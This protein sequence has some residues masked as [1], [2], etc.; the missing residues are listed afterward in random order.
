MGRSQPSTASPGSTAREPAEGTAE[1]AWWTYGVLSASDAGKL[2]SVVEGIEPGSSV[3]LV[4][5]GELAAMVSAVPADDYDDARLREHLEDLEWVERTARRHEA[6]L[7]AALNHA[8]VVPLRLCTLYRDHA[9]VRLLLREQAGPLEE[10]L[11]KVEGAAEWGVKVFAGNAAVADAEHAG[12]DHKTAAR[13]GAA[14]LTQRQ[15]ERER[16]EQRNELRVSCADAV[17]ARIAS[18]AREATINRPQHPKVHGR[19]MPMVLNGAYLVANDRQ[20]DLYGSI[21]ELQAEWGQMG[22]VIELTGPWPAYNFVAEP[23]GLTA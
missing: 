9:G 13:P 14:Y 11:A 7:D 3:E 5:E 10:A 18:C 21:T 20:A 12:E 23:P 17:H 15:R 22:F 19:D 8:T 2:E 16:A 4:S 1:R 6:V